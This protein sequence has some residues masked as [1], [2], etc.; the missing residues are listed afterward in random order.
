VSSS[1]AERTDA[2]GAA[3]AMALVPGF[4][5]GARR[6]AG[7]WLERWGHLGPKLA[8]LP[9]P[10]ALL[11]AWQLAASRGWVAAQILPAPATVLEALLDLARSGDLWLHLRASLTRVAAGFGLAAAAGLAL[12]AL[13]GLSRLAEGA[14]GTLF[15]A[16]AQTPVIAWVP[17]GILVFGIEDRLLVA[18]VASAAV[19]P[20]L[21]GTWKGVRA[22][23]LEYLEVARAYGYRGPRLL[24]R[25]IAPAAAPQ[26][27][28]GLRYGFNQAWLTL[29]AAELVGTTEG[30]GYLIVEARELF[31]LDVVLAV[32]LVL[33]AVGVLLDRLFALVEGRV[34]AH[35]PRGF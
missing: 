32:V 5:S 35:R 7:R 17:L 25:V 11:G 26:A 34:L 30:L 24:L 4:L 6:Q 2:V 23:P 3:T 8:A 12:G 21:L 31:Q 22:V 20:V 13:L 1:P 33:G 29:V 28:T 16:Y 14:L 27:L 10:V 18:L 15:K 9:V 19:V